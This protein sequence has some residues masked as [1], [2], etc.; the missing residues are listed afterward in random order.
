MNND[1]NGNEHEFKRPVSWLMGREL[2]AGLKWIAAYSF[3]GDKLGSK[4]WMHAEV[5]TP[6]HNNNDTACYWFDY[7]SDTGDGMKAVYNIAYLCMSDLWLDSQ[8]GI[9]ANSVALSADNIYNQQLPRGE[10]LFV[11]GDTAYH[12]ADIASL[13]ERFQAP[14][15]WAYQAI[16]A[17]TQKKPDKRPIYGIPANHDYY[18][19][20]NG[21]NLQFS[22]PIT[23]DT[24]E[25]QDNLLGLLGFDRT[26][27]TSYLALKL[28]F[29]WWLWG[30]DSQSGKM[31]KRQQAFFVSTLLQDKS[32]QDKPELV[33]N[34]DL[35]NN[36]RQ[37]TVRQILQEYSPAKLIVAT[38]E[39]TTVFGKWAKNDAAIINTF[40]YLGLESSFLE[41]YDGTLSAYKCRLDIAGDIH[42]YARYWGNT[43][44]NP[45]A[46]Y[47]SV[48]AG[49]GGAFLHP[50][51]T[52][53]NEAAQQALYPSRKDSHTLI[54]QAILNPLNI[55]QGGYIWL[56]GGLI[57]LL[58]YF[59]VTVP[60]NTWA[61]FKLLPENLRPDAT[62]TVLLYSMRN[63]LDT[64][65]ISDSM[66]CCSSAYYFD[67]SYIMLIVLLMGSQVYWLAK[68]DN[69]DRLKNVANRTW[70]KYVL[71]FLIAII[72]S[73]L[74][75]FNLISW[76]RK[77]LP[78]PMLA[79]LLIALFFITALLIFTLN[80]RYG[81]ILIKRSKLYKQTF[82]EVLPLWALTIAGLTYTV[83]GFLRYGL[84]SATITSFNLMMIFIWLLMTLGLVALAVIL[85]GQL[86]NNT[87][88]IK[89]AL[90]GIWHSFLQLT[91]PVC[92][93][94]YSS[95][96]NIM[97]ISIAATAITL[98][99]GYVFSRDFL[100][101]D[102]SLNQ[103][104][105]L[106]NLLFASWG[107]IGISVL[108]AA[109]AGNPVAISNWRLVAAFLLGLLF[110]CIWFGWYLAVSLA[111]NGHANEAGGGARSECYRHMIRFKLTANTLTGYVIGIDTPITEISVDHPPKFR[112]VDVFTLHAQ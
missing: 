25:L 9:S 19:V 36:A 20:L 51:H 71:I 56:V 110:S 85:G 73:F 84:Y 69:M 50:S 11:G 62:G 44:E 64:S 82:F 16:V 35:F 6:P 10:F 76:T 13:K 42:H 57:A 52:H 24:K 15:N 63:A 60:E 103:Q 81:D 38:P 97:A 21:F 17:N 37:N 33:K 108:L 27:T 68:P 28:P 99:A 58:S 93:V 26:Q 70:L 74:P 109:L 96:Y 31:D 41:K 100:V 86:L 65:G 54:T 43:T 40:T 47:A 22:K 111:Y 91:I 53:I 87:G 112:L 95:W 14:F 18:D 94:L 90:I 80:R 79:G 75:L 101:K 78:E 105:K 1:N 83:F 46:N 77:Q 66:Q 8:R 49:G 92:L 106:A 12:I 48:V 32:G 45:H 23:D 72:G 88:K 2:L 67:L 5:I 102:L 98:L 39:P 30:L 89:F 3:L 7:I 4:D 34:G 107:V 104:K 59:A 29:D 55:I 61:L